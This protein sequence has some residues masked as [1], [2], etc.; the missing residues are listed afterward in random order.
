[1]EK[2]SNMPPTASDKH[3]GAVDYLEQLNQQTE[4]Q[5]RYF[6][7]PPDTSF[8]GRCKRYLRDGCIA[9]GMA[10]AGVGLGVGYAGWYVLKALGYAAK[11]LF[12][13]VLYIAGV[14]FQKFATMILFVGFIYGAMLYLDHYQPGWRH[15]L[16]RYTSDAM[17]T[18]GE[19]VGAG[20]DFLAESG[21]QLKSVQTTIDNVAALSAE[22][23]A[24]NDTL[25]NF[26]ANGLVGTNV[27]DALSAIEDPALADKYLGILSESGGNLANGVLETSLFDDLYHGNAD[28]RTQAYQALDLL[29]TPEANEVLDYYQNVL[30]GN[31][32]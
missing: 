9:I 2:K 30:Q 21:A 27:T 23:K 15:E 5:E 8:I 11:S 24:L 28:I 1:M 17:Q 4:A 13:F 19:Y 32:Q 6:A 3:D 26:Q 18:A 29:D 10:I 16:A 25:T 7:P 12:N 22:V 14:V 31:A 20:K